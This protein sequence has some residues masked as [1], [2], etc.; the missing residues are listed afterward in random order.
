MD[1]CM[2]IR[3]V[4]SPKLSRPWNPR[5]E[6]LAPV[7]PME[8]TLSAAA[9]A[10]VARA[11]DNGT[12]AMPP[13][14]NLSLSDSP[15]QQYLHP[16]CR[17]R[18]QQGQ[19]ARDK[20]HGAAPVLP[21]L[22][23]PCCAHSGTTFLWRC[24]LHAFHPERVCAHLPAPRTSPATSPTTT[25]PSPVHLART[26]ADWSDH[27]C[28][29]R[30]Y[31]LPGLT[32]N[33]QGHWDYRKEWFFFGGGSTSWEKGWDDYVGVKLPLCYWELGFQRQLRLRPLDDT[34]AHSRRLCTVERGGVPCTH[35]A[36]LPLDLD[37]VAFGPQYAQQYDRDTKPRWQLQATKALP[38]VN[39]RRHP[40]AIVSDFTPNYLCSPKALRNVLSS[41][42]TPKHLRFLVLVRPPLRVLTASY[43]MF[44]HWNWV[45]SENLTAAASAQLA[46]LRVC[47]A[48]LYEHPERLGA[49]PPAEV[50]GFFS[51]CWEGS[52][53]HFVTNALPAACLHAWLAAGFRREQ[54]L[55]VRTERMREAHP[56]ALLHGIANFT[57]LYYHAEFHNSDGPRREELRSHCA[58][59]SRGSGGDGSGGALGRH[60]WVNSHQGDSER[61]ARARLAGETYAEFIRLANAYSAELNRLNLRELF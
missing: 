59:P 40:G 6:Q 34:L 60:P 53:R 57:G 32:G 22:L 28:R 42:G 5:K 27:K 7:L 44:V 45:R 10:G 8:R 39:G 13:P 55:I 12:C 56:D 25:F 21:S 16:L 24:M 48:T 33:I 29:G 23:V 31:L 47:N 58:A 20:A 61:E 37:K 35:R 11:S 54:F 1:A 43:R 3:K 41:L 38:R 30:R 50:F 19:T 26:S 9:L 52:W 51:R 46:E 4:F 49:L 36:C 15:D 14:A 17:P 2:L 18:R